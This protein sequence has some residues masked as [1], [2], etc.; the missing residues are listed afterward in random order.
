MSSSFIF[1]HG[2]NL[3]NVV[4]NGQKPKICH[5][6]FG[7]SE[8]Y[9]TR[10][11]QLP[12][13]QLSFKLYSGSR[14]S[15]LEFCS[16]Q[17]ANIFLSICCTALKAFCRSRKILHQIWR[18]PFVSGEEPIYNRRKE[19]SEASICFPSVHRTALCTAGHRTPLQKWSMS[20]DLRHQEWLANFLYNLCTDM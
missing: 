10:S 2:F 12:F 3:C 9:L 5:I 1:L 16:V 14:A 11:G 4:C 20:K 15:Q 19:Q 18:A 6:R 8:I 13:R 7:F 17:R